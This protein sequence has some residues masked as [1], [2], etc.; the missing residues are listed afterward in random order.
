MP[1]NYTNIYQSARGTTRYTQEQAAELLEISVESVKAYENDLRLP[2]HQTVVRM[3]QI[4]DAP[5]LALEHLKRTAEPLGVIPE[6]RVQSLPT[7]VISLIN[8]AADFRENH[9]KLLRI[10]EDGIIDES[11]RPVFE[12]LAGELEGLISAAYSV[13]YPLGAQK[14]TAPTFEGTSKRSALRITPKNDCTN[15]IA[16][17][18]SIAQEISPREGGE[19][20]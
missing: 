17:Q 18:V 10:A 3:A 16:H 6:V 4:Y 9:R 19:I 15:I 7:A 11:E 13:I 1:E 20:L 14:K 2:P 5:W 12:E 8:R